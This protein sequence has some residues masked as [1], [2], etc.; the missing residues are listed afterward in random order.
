MTTQ[1][2]TERGVLLCTLAAL[3]RQRD[4]VERELRV[5]DQTIKVELRGLANRRGIA[6]IRLEHLRRE[7]GI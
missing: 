1:D 5:M 7:L 2:Q 6:F 3:I 4:Q